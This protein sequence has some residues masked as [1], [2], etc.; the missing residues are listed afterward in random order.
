M[1]ANKTFGYNF[2]SYFCGTYF[3]IVKSSG[4]T[5][6]KK[7][8]NHSFWLF[9]NTVGK[10]FY[11]PEWKLVWN[12]LDNRA[13]TNGFPPSLV[14]VFRWTMPGA[15]SWMCQ[16]SC[17]LYPVKIFFSFLDST[18]KVGKSIN[19]VSILPRLSITFA[20]NAWGGWT[21][22]SITNVDVNGQAYRT[23]FPSLA[24]N[25]ILMQQQNPNAYP[26]SKM[27]LYLCTR[28]PNKFW[29]S[30]PCRKSKK[31]K[32]EFCLFLNKKIVKLKQFSRFFFLVLLQK[33]K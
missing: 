10:D 22:V 25:L 20:H 5:D 19:S 4:W 2:L 15:N 9:S 6:D 21:M 24:C 28:C 13:L 7:S 17:S 1:I 8:E 3:S 29:I 11:H 16:K 31:A 12:F 33:L 32:S 27:A 23:Q 26:N 30:S 18:L 14:L